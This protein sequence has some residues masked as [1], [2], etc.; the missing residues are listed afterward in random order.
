MSGN[1]F[2]IVRGRG[3]GFGLCVGAAAFSLA[4][5]V[6]GA[7][8][9]GGPFAGMGGAWSGTGTVSMKTGT[10]ERIR[11]T[12]QYLVKND[13]NNF[14]QALRCQSASYK[15]EVNAYVNH[16]GGSLSGYWTELVNNVKG[17]VSGKADG[18]HVDALLS[19]T[20]FSATL[21]LVTKG[22]SQQVVIEPSADTSTQVQ[23]VSITL[24]KAG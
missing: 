7:A 1:G 23:Q 2:G 8:H 5:A 3:K 10:K 17:G 13:D 15:F 16:N 20:G 9:A 6:S 12:A 22:A 24:R 21:D 4:V 19:G 14:Q 18:N 11:C